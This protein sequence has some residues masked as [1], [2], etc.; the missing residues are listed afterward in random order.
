MVPGILLKPDMK[1]E[2]KIIYYYYIHENTSLKS[3]GVSVGRSILQDM[4]Q[5]AAVK[6]YH[7]PADGLVLSGN[8][9]N[10]WSSYTKAGVKKYWKS[11]VSQ[12]SYVEDWEFDLQPG[13]FMMV[14]ERENTSQPDGS[15]ETSEPFSG[16]VNESLLESQKLNFKTNPD[17]IEVI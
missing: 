3:L 9:E 8:N 12:S 4:K 2:Q 16:D 1:T 13:Y 7:V 11:A 15:P 14:I 5:F 6:F 10:N 17:L